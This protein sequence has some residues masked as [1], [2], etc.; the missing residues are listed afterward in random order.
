MQILFLQQQW[1]T[2]SK[3]PKL[4]TMNYLM[5]LCFL[6]LGPP[7]RSAA[8]LSVTIPNIKENRGEIVI[9]IFDK[10][11]SFPK[12]G[13][14]YRTIRFPVESKEAVYVLEDIDLGSYAIAI[15]HDENHDGKCN[16]DFLGIPKEG[17]G[18][19]NNVK[20]ILRAPSF[21]SCEIKLL[22]NKAISVNLIY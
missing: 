6:V 3:V 20:P 17:Y 10:S 15:Y 18:F 14:P 16:V 9:A 2:N 12:Y 11:E 8:D 19:S 22:D 13:D 1:P 4:N 5:M 7:E 21:E